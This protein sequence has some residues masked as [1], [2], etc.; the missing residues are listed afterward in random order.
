MTEDAAGATQAQEGGGNVQA[1][2]ALTS[3]TQAGSVPDHA[4]HTYGSAPPAVLSAEPTQHR[5]VGAQ[6][7][8]R[9]GPMQTHAGHQCQLRP[10]HTRLLFSPSRDAW[11]LPVRLPWATVHPPPRG[12]LRPTPSQRSPSS[13]LTGVLGG[14]CGSGGL[15]SFSSL[16]WSRSSADAHT[17]GRA[18]EELGAPGPP[19]HPPPRQPG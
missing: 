2:A 5:G 12:G 4:H 10:C 14:V 15:F 7:Q 1:G 18:C 9:T 19:H 17:A 11:L 8:R 16:V 6:S 3:R 13:R